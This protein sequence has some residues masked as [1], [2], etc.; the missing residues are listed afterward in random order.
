MITVTGVPEG[1]GAR[2]AEC[3]PPD[4]LQGEKKEKG[5][6]GKKKKKGKGERKKKRKRKK[7]KGKKKE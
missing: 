4:G 7:G 2:G 1:G 5:G 6:R 3:P